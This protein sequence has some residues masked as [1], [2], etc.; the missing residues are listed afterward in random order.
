MTTPT[1]YLN[2]LE[3]EI[4]TLRQE[5]VELI[6]DIAQAIAGD[7]E[8]AASDRRRLGEI[9]QDLREMFFMVVV[10]GEFNAGKS[11]FINAMLG[12]RL[13]DTG[14]TPTTEYIELVRYNETPQTVPVLRPDGI[15]EW[16]H[17][18][19]GAPGVAIVDTPGT[20]SIFMKHERVAR[21]FLHRSDLVIF[22]LSAKQAFAES[23]R[24]YLELT[25][26]YGKKVILVI[27][28]IDLLTPAEQS[29]VLDFVR[30]KVKETLNLEPPI[31]MIS[32]RDA[33]EA[34]PD[35]DA[36]GLDAVKAHLRGVY[37]EARPAKQKL[38]AELD[39]V[40]RL[41]AHHRKAAQDRTAVVTLD[42][43]RVKNIESEMSAQSTGLDHRQQEINREI[44]AVLEGIRARGLSFI[45]K[46]LTIRWSGPRP[47]KE[48]LEREFQEVVIGRSV[49]DVT[50][51][52]HG[53]INTVVD[54]SRLYWN[55]VLERLNR[56]QD[57]LEQQ[58]SAF[59]AG[60]Y[61]EQ[62]ENLEQA[63]RIADRELQANIAGQTLNEL[64][65]QFDVNLSAFQRNALFTAGGL[66]AI[67]AAFALHGPIVGVAAS[68]LALPLLVV[69]GA[70]ALIAGVPAARAYRR[71]NYK[72]KE[73]FNRRVDTLM[74]TYRDALEDLTRK[75]RSR[76]AQYGR[77]QLVPI[78]SRLDTLRE[79]YQARQAAMDALQRRLAALRARLADVQ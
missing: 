27:N 53:Y 64:K 4:A 6:H 10:M 38:L 51:L 67:I 8:Q 17:P 78:Y 50:E 72:A 71:A 31:F 52:V 76:L 60:I 77:Q 22:V 19:T 15:R 25:R 47:S 12:Y 33:M 14:I 9:A 46:N 5:E 42:V 48:T 59:D 41:L 55:S 69:G 37:S 40:E 24:L 58:K 65:G 79:E 26:S 3:G 57:V 1:L 68:P 73:D 11:T 36:G 30:A 18:G 21:D 75:E 61:S 32:A 63:I 2:V 35:G 34:A 39:T 56:L 13:L 28:Q 70:V 16:A 49:R 45:D 54:Q 23:E 44:M 20:G 66:G 7:D 74:K 62:R 29:Q 43:D